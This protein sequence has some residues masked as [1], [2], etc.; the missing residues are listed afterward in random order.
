MPEAAA[1]GL[2][3][4]LRVLRQ[5]DFVLKI[6]AEKLSNAIEL[7]EAKVHME[8]C[9]EA[10]VIA[11]SNLGKAKVALHRAK[12]KADPTQASLDPWGDLSDTDVEIDPRE[13]KKQR[14]WP[15]LVKAETPRNRLARPWVL[16]VNGGS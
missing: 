6:E 1:V 3:D 7:V 16:S 4:E 9:K 8:G 2:R 11:C 5:K 14:K 15:S 13:C 12:K 10:V